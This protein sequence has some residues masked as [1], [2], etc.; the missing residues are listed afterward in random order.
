MAQPVLLLRTKTREFFAGAS[1][2]IVVF[3]PLSSPVLVAAGQVAP[4]DDAARAV[5]DGLGLMDVTDA[6]WVLFKLGMSRGLTRWVVR[7]PCLSDVV[8]AHV[9]LGSRQ[10]IMSLGLANSVIERARVEQLAW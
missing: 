7:G 9:A 1:V 4:Q 6:L 10:G 3:S 2:H 5:A 8:G